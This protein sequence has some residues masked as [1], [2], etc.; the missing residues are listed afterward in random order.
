MAD[1]SGQYQKWISIEDP[2]SRHPNLAADQQGDPFLII[3]PDKRFPTGSTVAAQQAADGTLFEVATASGGFGAQW[4]RPDRGTF[5]WSYY[6][7]VANN[8]WLLPSAQRTSAVEV[9]VDEMRLLRAEAAYRMNNRG[10]A[11]NL[12]NVTRTAAGLN[13]TD[14]A[15]A[16]T[17]CVPKLRTGACGDLFEMLKWEVRLETMYQG[18]HMAP[19]YFH[20]RGW[21]DLA[22]GTFLQF[23]VPGREASLLNIPAYTFGGIGGEAAAPVGNYGY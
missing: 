11:A 3:T 6:R 20:G 16:N 4:A 9:S 21:G 5:R 17:S 19:W 12:I 15:G 14:A 22:E 1:Q 13:A 8:M 18:L 23:P 7:Y 10:E 2:W